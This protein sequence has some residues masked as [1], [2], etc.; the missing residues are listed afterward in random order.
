MHIEP[1]ARFKRCVF[2]PTDRVS[3][4]AAS[5]TGR[6]LV[7]LKELSFDRAHSRHEPVEFGEKAFLVL[8]GLFDEIRGCA[9]AHPVESIGQ[10]P[11]QKPHMQLQIQK[12][13]ME[14]ALLHH[15]RDLAR[16]RGSKLK[17]KAGSRFLQIRKFKLREN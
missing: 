12:F 11:V 8:L 5:V 15:G 9:V 7:E 2:A 10:L 14:L 17:L 3:T 6:A 16:E 4:V 13:L 1:E